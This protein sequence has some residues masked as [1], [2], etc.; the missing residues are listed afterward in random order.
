MDAPTDVAGLVV[1]LTNFR[2][3]VCEVVC[4]MPGFLLANLKSNLNNRLF[5]LKWSQRAKSR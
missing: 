3:G 1:L 2:E 5:N 4:Y